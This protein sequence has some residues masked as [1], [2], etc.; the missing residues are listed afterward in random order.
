MITL[1]LKKKIIELIIDINHLRK[2]AKL[3]ILSEFIAWIAFGIY[4]TIYQFYL[5]NPANAGYDGIMLGIVF[6]AY[7][8]TSSILMIPGG[9]IADNY[10]RKKI[11]IIG[12][13]LSIPPL[14]MIIFST[15]FHIVLIS[16]I[17]LGLSYAFSGPIF[18]ALFSDTLD[19]NEMDFGFSV[20]ALFQSFSLA[21]GSIFGWI[22]S[23]LN[24]KFNYAL[25]D[26]YKVVIGLIIILIFISVIPILMIKPINKIKRG[27][28]L[29]LKIKSSRIA[30]KFMIINAIV[31]FG[32]G[33][34]IQMFGYYFYKKFGIRE[35]AYGTLSFIT[36]IMCSPTFL[37]APRL[38]QKMGILTTIIYT[39]LASVPGLILITFSPNF[40]IASIIFIYRQAMM[41]MANPLIGSLFMKLTKEEERAT[42]NSLSTLSWSISN[43]LG[44]PIGGYMIDNIMV[45]LPPYVT[46]IFYIVYVVLFYA[47]IKNEVSNSSFLEQ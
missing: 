27:K 24:T 16:S 34:T 28:R 13:L 25:I 35:D 8:I 10:G 32:A 5:I 7:N 11:F 1:N 26:S 3:M 30:L 33:M 21:I 46:S 17:I 45:D 20:V 12:T 2:D 6:M 41:N 9:L 37:I 31:A 18:S 15:H 19:R 22:P 4:Y 47:L 29:N 23:I 39:Q 44:M 43:A 36:N 42:V 40:A 38:S 14:I